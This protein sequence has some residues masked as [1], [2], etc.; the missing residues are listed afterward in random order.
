MKLC[1]PE[2]LFGLD[3]EIDGRLPP[4]ETLRL[5]REGHVEE[6][7]FLNFDFYNSKF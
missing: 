7:F 2:H 5:I 6:L 4:C 3:E 1:N